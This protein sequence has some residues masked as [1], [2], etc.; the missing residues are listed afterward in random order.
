MMAGIPL[1]RIGDAIRVASWSVTGS[2]RSDEIGRRYAIR[3]TKDFG[4]LQLF[5]DG[6]FAHGLI[7][8]AEGRLPFR[9][10]ANSAFA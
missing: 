10:G 2:T 8:R 3:L 7:D 1:P 9:T 6:R 4:C 5:V